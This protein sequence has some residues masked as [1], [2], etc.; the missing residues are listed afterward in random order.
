VAITCWGVGN[1]IMAPLVPL[2]LVDELR[3]SY[4][5][6]GL[7]GLVNSAFWMVFYVIWGRAVDRRGGLWT[8]KANVFLTAFVPLAL[9]LA[10][11]LWLV[12]VAYIVMGITNAG[13]DLGWINTIMQF[14]R[15]GQ[16][17]DYTALYAGLAGIRGL[18]M[19]LL[20]TALLAVPWIGLRGVFL[21]STLLILGSAL[22]VY[23]VRIP[24]GGP[25]ELPDLR[26]SG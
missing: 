14:G 6:V 20:G 5:Q 18:I 17:A 23:R 7:L 12:A 8:M 15:R 24:A 26:L 13:G 4:S 10:G 11:D 22:L 1:L 21:L 25:A 2:L 16:V 19:P 3:L 9:F